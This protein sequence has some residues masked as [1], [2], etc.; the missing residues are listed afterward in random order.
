MALSKAIKERIEREALGQVLTSWEELS[1]EQVLDS[2][3]NDGQTW[4]TND[5]ITVWQVFED[6]YADFVAEQIEDVHHTLTDLAESVADAV[7][8]SVIQSVE[9]ILQER[10]GQ[11]AS[12]AMRLLLEDLGLRGE[13]SDG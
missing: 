6:T 4:N 8:Q 11:P 5:D 2:L 10:S 12:Q 7:H 13:P 3:R 9:R 1:Y